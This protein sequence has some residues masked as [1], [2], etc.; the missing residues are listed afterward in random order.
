MK[1]VQKHFFVLSV[2]SIKRSFHVPSMYYPYTVVS[3]YPFIV[4]LYSEEYLTRIHAAR[5]KN[6]I[7]YPFIV[8][9]I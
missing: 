9:S 7:K 4:S 6:P 1:C 8:K 3:K 5:D 2:K